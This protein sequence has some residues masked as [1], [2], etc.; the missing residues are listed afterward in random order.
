MEPSRRGIYCGS[1]FY[2][3]VRGE[4]DSSIA[5]RTLLVRDG[6]VSCWGGGGIV[7]DSHWEDEYQETLDKVRVLLE[8]LEGMAGT[9]S[10]NSPRSAGSFIGG[11]A[12]GSANGWKP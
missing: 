7:A 3:D 11:A 10:R 9:A 4:M 5:I 8:T 2:L 12:T 1:L 6:Q